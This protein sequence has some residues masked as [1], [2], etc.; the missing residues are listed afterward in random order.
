VVLTLVPL[1]WSLTTVVGTVDDGAPPTLVD[2]A[3]ATSSSVQAFADDV[4]AAVRARA[5][6]EGLAGGLRVVLEQVRGLDAKKT[7]AAL[8]PRL[9]KALAGGP[10][11]TVETA[12]LTATLAISAERGQL[13]A[14][15]VIDG[16]ASAA[17]STVVVRRAL[18]REL[19]VA[20]GTVAR[21][22]PGRLSLQRVG[23]L[24]TTA[25][26]RPCPTLDAALIDVEV[27]GVDELAVLTVCGVSVFAVDE[28]GI[29]LVAGPFALPARRWPRVALGWLVPVAVTDA[30]PRLWLATS[31]GHGLLLDVTTGKLSDAPAERVPLRGVTSKEGPWSLRWRLG[32]PVLSLPLVTPGG[33]D[34]VV[35]GL[36][37]RVRDLARVPGSEA[38]VVVSEDGALLARHESGGG[39]LAPDRV[40]DRVL[41]VDLDGDSE[42]EVLTT[43]S[44][45][46]GEPDQLVVR[47]LDP[48]HD[49]SR[50]VLRSSLGGGSVA[51][52]SA[53]RL[54]DDRRVD[55]IVV[56]ES[57]D[58]AAQVW[59]LE[60]SP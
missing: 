12:P 29:S 32:S 16:P 55:V 40:G 48:S 56:E 57:A 25:G 14:V 33:V 22:F 20:L 9:K 5:A 42:I 37:T 19:E 2:P 44:A 39:A 4:A 17:S 10:L 36:P 35:Q 11:V 49:G 21:V 59:R 50:V 27:D 6:Q 60:H 38:F 18:D 26:A 3:A 53:G 54:D 41:V 43:T 45:S 31:A 28:S 47:R 23:P 8:L 52:V 1:L 30:G 15:V 13:W 46:P 34:I 51:A 58:G 24:P 7:R